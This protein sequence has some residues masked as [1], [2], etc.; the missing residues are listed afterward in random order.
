M[1]SNFLTFWPSYIVHLEACNKGS[2][3]FSLY[4]MVDL[5][6]AFQVRHNELESPYS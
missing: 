4:S 3:C 2:L 1:K 6:S 5:R